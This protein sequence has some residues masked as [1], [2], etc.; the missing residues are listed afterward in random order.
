MSRISDIYDFFR[1]E[2]ATLFPNK[3]ELDVGNND[4]LEFN[5]LQLLEDGWGF[6]VGAGVNTKRLVGC[7]QS[8][9]REFI[10]SLTKEVK[11]LVTD[12]SKTAKYEKLLLEDHYTFMNFVHTVDKINSE[13]VKIDYE[14]DSGIVPIIIERK[15]YR[16]IQMTIIVEYF[17]NIV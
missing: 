6:H 12:N 17:E 4:L 16:A 5:A 11:G 3:T 14:N 10:I 2:L 9:Q 7:K 15:N 1:T 8:I 13:N